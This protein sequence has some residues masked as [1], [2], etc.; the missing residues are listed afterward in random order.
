MMAV[1]WDGLWVG[2]RCRG[3][4]SFSCGRCS[5]GSRPSEVATGFGR[6]RRVV[7]CRV[8]A[9]I[10][11]TAQFVGFDT[12]VGDRERSTRRACKSRVQHSAQTVPGLNATWQASQV[13]SSD[14]ST[15]KSKM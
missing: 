15:F 13:Q 8:A 6:V 5:R 9:T 10:H 11:G 3:K 14:F 1:S 7:L 12:G 4:A 2:P